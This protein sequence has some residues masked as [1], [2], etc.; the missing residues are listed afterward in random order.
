MSE[1]NRGGMSHPHRMKAAGEKEKKEKGRKG[2]KPG[3]YRI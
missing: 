2:G 3:R 1:M